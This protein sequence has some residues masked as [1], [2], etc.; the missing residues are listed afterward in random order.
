MYNFV[1]YFL[2][3]KLISNITGPVAKKHWVQFERSWQGDDFLK[4]NALGRSPLKLSDDAY[5]KPVRLTEVFY[6]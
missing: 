1:L 6:L 3:K 2:Y 5:D 4:R